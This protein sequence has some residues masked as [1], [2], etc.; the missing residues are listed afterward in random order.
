[1]AVYDYLG[2]AAAI[3]RKRAR[4][5]DP[6]YRP[7]VLDRGRGHG[8]TLRQTAPVKHRAPVSKMISRTDRSHLNR[9]LATALAHANANHPGRANQAA[10][11]LVVKLHTLGVLGQ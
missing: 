9:Q 8:A 11:R 1:M 4:R 10:Q 5:P 6:N 7:S 2:A 3:D